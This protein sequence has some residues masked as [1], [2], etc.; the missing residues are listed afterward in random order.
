MNKQEKYLEN[1]ILN[2]EELQS[3]IKLWLG[4]T[5]SQ[6]RYCLSQLAQ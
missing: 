4:T 6:K 2:P 3:N 1:K 5:T